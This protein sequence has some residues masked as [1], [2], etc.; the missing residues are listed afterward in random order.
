LT[1]SPNLKLVIVGTANS[2]PTNITLSANTIAENNDANAPVGDLITQ[3]PNVGDTFTY[4]FV[5]G[6]GDS[7]N[8]SFG[9]LNGK[10]IA[11]GKLD[12][13]TKSNYSIRIRATDQ[14]GLF[15]E[16]PLTI[17]VTN[18][19]EAPS[20]TS[21]GVASAAENQTA[22]QTV[23]GTDPDAGTTL[24]YRIVPGADAAE[25]VIN[26]GT[27]ELAFVLAP[28]FE[29]PTDVGANNVYNLTVEVSDGTLTATKAV[30]VTVT[31]VMDS[32]ADYKVDWLTAN[33]LAADS[34]LNSDPNNVGYSLATA[35]AFGLDPR[36][37]SGAPVTIVSSATG[38]VKVV[39]LQR[40][41]GGVTYAVK[42]GTDL[43]VGLNGSVTPTLSASQPSPAI[44]GYTRYEATYTPAAP[45]TKGFVKVQANVP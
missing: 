24:S 16:A 44:P 20:L 38:S 31:N 27:G 28:D 23:T 30:A 3:D 7:D 39:Y 9:I 21:A 36:V 8:G 35:Y 40:D 10:L 43:A 1:N 33:G 42:T 5:T 2:A 11:Q 25:F 41:N 6:A 14:G 15:V 29:N 34:N 13:E 12:Y 18:V 37:R 26:S 4:S 19:N 45:A 22:V 17:T 32:Q